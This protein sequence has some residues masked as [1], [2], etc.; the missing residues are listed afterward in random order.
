MKLSHR[1]IATLFCLSLSAE[2]RSPGTEAS[3]GDSPTA[4]P[5]EAPAV[6][7]L[8][9]TPA[10][11]PAVATNTSSVARETRP[12]TISLARTRPTTRLRSEGL[13]TR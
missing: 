6:A 12:E 5:V 9:S 11:T 1:V 4:P 3:N 2:C 10:N 13:E 8:G 7:A